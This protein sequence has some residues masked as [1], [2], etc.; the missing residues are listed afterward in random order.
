[1]TMMSESLLLQFCYQCDLGSVEDTFETLQK[2]VS[3]NFEA[4][5]E[6]LRLQNTPEVEDGHNFVVETFSN[7]KKTWQPGNN[8]YG[9]KRIFT[10]NKNDSE[11]KWLNWIANSY[12]G[13]IRSPPSLN[14]STCSSC[15]IVKLPMY[16]WP[17]IDGPTRTM[18]LGINVN[19]W[20]IENPMAYYI[21]VLSPLGI[22]RP[23]KIWRGQGINH[24][25]LIQVIG[26]TA[27]D[28][29]PTLRTR[30]VLNNKITQCFC[31]MK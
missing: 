18:C 23:N 17:W 20:M 6:D 27:Y 25:N 16:Q 30:Q 7:T 28:E 19:D 26:K 4:F 10:W 15:S 8:I 12:N 29:Q 1:M 24:L 31:I 11:D 22:S 9:R 14:K 21:P 5:L 3:W 2:R 13:E